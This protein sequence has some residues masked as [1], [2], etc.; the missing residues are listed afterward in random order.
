MRGQKKDKVQNTDFNLSLNE[1][2]EEYNSIKNSPEQVGQ[3]MTLNENVIFLS[4]KCSDSILIEEERAIDLTRLYENAVNKKINQ[5]ME[6]PMINGKKTSH[7]YCTTIAEVEF[8]DVKFQIKEIQAY[9]SHLKRL[10]RAFSEFSRAISQR[11]SSY[12]KNI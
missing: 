12:Y 8:N 10:D 4:V 6:K 9:I 2:I 5:L 3:I 7:A 1:I 11:I